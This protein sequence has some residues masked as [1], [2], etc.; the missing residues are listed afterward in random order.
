MEW[1]QLIYVWISKKENARF[2][3]ALKS[4]G[5]AAESLIRTWIADYVEKH[6]ED[7]AMMKVSEEINRLQE[8]SSHSN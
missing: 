6:E 4:N 1:N 3:A 2:N 7:A 5:D 8:K